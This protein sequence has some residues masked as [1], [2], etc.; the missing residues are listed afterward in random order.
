MKTL[1]LLGII[2]F[3][4]ILGLGLFTSC[5]EPADSTDITITGIPSQYEGMYISGGAYTLGGGS[6]QG[7]DSMK[8]VTNGE[9]KLELKDFNDEKDVSLDGKYTIAIM[10][11][12]SSSVPA[13]T[14]GRDWFIQSKELGGGNNKIEF[15]EFSR[16][17][18]KLF[19]SV[20]FLSAE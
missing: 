15:S 17:S 9:A 1:K 19:G 8:K 2:A 20:L 12:Q 7:V 6:A 4:A 11:T 16:S 14:V 10:I 3:A 18:Q 5:E 13:F